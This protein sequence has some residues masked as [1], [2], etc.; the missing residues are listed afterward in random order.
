MHIYGLYV[1]Y[2]YNVN[3]ELY[4]IYG[5]HAI[6]NIYVT[7]I[8]YAI[9]ILTIQNM[10]DMQYIQYVCKYVH[11][12]IHQKCIKYLGPFWTFPKS[13]SLSSCLPRLEPA[14]QPRPELSEC[15]VIARAQ[16]MCVRVLGKSPARSSL[17]CKVSERVCVICTCSTCEGKTPSNSNVSTRNLY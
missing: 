7:Y 1:Q 4:A 8:Q 5:V 14:T 9:H 11:V 3:Y 13:V 12:A 16:W 6:Y 2:T 15:S 17:A 10:S